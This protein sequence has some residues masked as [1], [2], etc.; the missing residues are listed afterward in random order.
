MN[1]I[2]EQWM[3]AHGVALVAPTYW[4][5]SPSPLKRM[6]DRLACA[7]SG[8]PEPSLTSGKDPM[9]ARQVELDGWPR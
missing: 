9:K 5:Q 1:G 8:N 3:S 4:Y 6:I 7:D 2:Y